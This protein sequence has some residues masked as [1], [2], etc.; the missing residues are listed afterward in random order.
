MLLNPALFV[1]QIM[2]PTHRL[3]G[4]VLYGM[5]LLTIVAPLLWW[6]EVEP[7]YSKSS[8]KLGHI[9]SVN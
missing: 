7:K 4:F 1:G 9:K 3:R 8:H 2:R 6:D 5:A